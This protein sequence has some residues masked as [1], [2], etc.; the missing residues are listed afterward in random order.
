MI[1]LSLKE[2]RLIAKN[3]GINGYKS[4]SNDRL[5]SMLDE[6]KQV[7]N[8]RDTRDIIKGN[9]DSDKIL[10]DKNFV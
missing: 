8:A 3:I 6:S 4:M 10:K 9:S 5:L 1:N 2:L 7:K